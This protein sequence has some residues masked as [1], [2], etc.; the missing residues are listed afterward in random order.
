MKAFALEPAEERADFIRYGSETPELAPAW[1]ECR[2]LLAGE[3][4]RS[5][6][7]VSCI[8]CPSTSSGP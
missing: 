1:L 7:T 2:S 3:T 6:Q 4:K 5:E 8:A